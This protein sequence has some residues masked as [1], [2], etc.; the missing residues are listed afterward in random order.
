MRTV[1]ALFVVILLSP[2]VSA[3]CVVPTVTVSGKVTDRR[4]SGISDAAVAVSWVQDG[5]P[6]GPAQARTDD[7]GDFLVKFAFNTFTKHSF[8]RGDVC[9][10][11]LLNVSVSAFMPGYRSEYT[12]VPVNNWSAT[13]HLEVD[14]F[15]E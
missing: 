15:R 1:A 2:T 4:G 8:L 6:Q 9:R 3:K 10:E 13:V 7:Q 12:L 11:R 5:M 14:T